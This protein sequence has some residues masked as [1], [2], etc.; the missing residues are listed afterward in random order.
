MSQTAPA[1]AA[2]DEAATEARI[3]R[4]IAAEINAAPKQVAAAAA[5]VLAAL[6][7]FLWGARG[8]AE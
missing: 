1:P 3:A 5:V 8:E 6:V 2:E 4:A 7:V